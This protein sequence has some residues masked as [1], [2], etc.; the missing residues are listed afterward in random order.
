[1]SDELEDTKPFAK[2]DDFASKF[3]VNQ[4]PPA[5]VRFAAASD[6]GKVR[7]NNEDHFAVVHR[8]RSQNLLSTNLP[9]EHFSAI[10]DE[11]YAFVV[12]DGLGGAVAGE[13]ASRIVMEEA[14]DLSA[15]AGSWVMKF[16]N[17]S[18]HQFEERLNAYASKMQKKLVE[19]SN[20]N[21]N[22]R[23]MATTWTSVYVVGWDAIIAHIGDSRAYVYRDGTLQQLTLDHTIGQA[24]E[25]A[26]VATEEAQKYRHIL[27]N[28]L[29]SQ[30]DEAALDVGHF[31]LQ[32][33]DRMLLCTDGLS[34]VVP[35]GELI[36][37][38]R[39]M[40]EPRGLCNA[41][42]ARALDRGGKDNITV[43]IADFSKPD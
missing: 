40:V 32:H 12:T 28:A 6:A 23:G 18:D 29:D 31:E 14:W 27:T 25:E 1:M 41:L 17:L 34:D 15:Q 9:R 30:G 20:A 4:K 2:A 7:S 11:A 22:T 13:L 26:G 43:I 37:L 10:R 5:N 36:E 21:P 39:D 33:N 8:Y 24:F 35:E 38:F 16:H 19:F 42:I 3:F